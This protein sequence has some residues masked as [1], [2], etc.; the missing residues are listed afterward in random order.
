[1]GLLSIHCSSLQF[2]CIFLEGLLGT[3]RTC[4]FFM[5]KGIRRCKEWEIV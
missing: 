3:S 1:M 2:L 5:E 4:L